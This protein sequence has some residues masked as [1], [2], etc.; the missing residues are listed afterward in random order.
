MNLGQK[1]RVKVNGKKVEI[2]YR[3]AN[4]LDVNR[5]TDSIIVSTQIGIKVLWDGISFLEVSAP[6]SYRGRLCGLCGN[7]NSLPKDDFTNRRGKLLQDPQPFGQSWLVGAKRSCVRPKP[8]VSPDRAKR[9]RGRKDHRYGDVRSIRRTLF[10][11]LDFTRPTVASK[12]NNM[13]V[14]RAGYAT[15]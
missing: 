10:G 14:C 13:D 6:T 5:T 1:M 15:G 9:C 7:F 3:M 11:Y 12:C 2:P 4:R 8:S